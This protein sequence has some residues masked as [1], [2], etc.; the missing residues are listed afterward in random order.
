MPWPS[1][2][3]VCYNESSIYEKYGTPDVLQLRDIANQ[4]PKTMKYW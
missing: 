2:K 1:Y 4:L 3:N